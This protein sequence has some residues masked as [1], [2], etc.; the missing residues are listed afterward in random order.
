M[1][2]LLCH[3]LLVLKALKLTLRKTPDERSGTGIPGWKDSVAL[4][5]YASRIACRKH[6]GKYEKI[7][8]VAFFCPADND[9]QFVGQGLLFIAGSRFAAQPLDAVLEVNRLKGHSSGYFAR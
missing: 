3:G 1:L 9:D 2:L 7:C 8:Q 5:R 4:T 6:F